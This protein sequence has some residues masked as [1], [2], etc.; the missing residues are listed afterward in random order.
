MFKDVLELPV[1]ETTRTTYKQRAVLFVG[2]Y[3][4]NDGFSELLRVDGWLTGLPL[5]FFFYPGLPVNLLCQIPVDS[6]SSEAVLLAVCAHRM[7]ILFFFASKRLA[8]V[9][10]T[11]HGSRPGPPNAAS[12]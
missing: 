12:D 11:T 1:R 9:C 6:H 5:F 10:A 2:F 4:W 8:I 3:Y 7:S